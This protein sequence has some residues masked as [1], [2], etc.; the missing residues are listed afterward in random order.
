MNKPY[1][2]L[3]LKSGLS[4]SVQASS[5]HYCEPRSDFGPYTSFEI[6]FPSEKIDKIMGYAE[7]P[8]KPTSTV[9][10]YVPSQVVMEVIK[11]NLGIDYKA[12]GLSVPFMD[13]IDQKTQLEDL[14]DVQHQIWAH[15]M[16]YMFSQGTFNDDDTWTIPAEK[17]E[18]WRGQS[19]TPYDLLTE[20]E[21][22]SD[23][24]QVRK[25]EHLI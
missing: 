16:K 17:V 14:A 6:G 3:I 1:P 12:M 15:W 4:L 8:D 19:V 21:K 24:E 5:N 20:K 25:F 18:R 11:D 13:L 23:R 10:A 7:N 2:V 22:E 9:Y